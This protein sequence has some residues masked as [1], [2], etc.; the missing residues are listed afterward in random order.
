MAKARPSYKL[1]SRNDKFTKKLVPNEYERV[2]KSVEL[3]INSADFLAL[4]S[5]GW[6][7]ISCNR[8][9]NFI[10]HTPTPYLFSSINATADIHSGQ[11][12]ADLM[13]IEIEKLGYFL[14]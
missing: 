9:I 14:N 5:D 10:V 2:K 11:H 6:T 7:D 1:P 3:A 4:S 13:S 12:I 8:L